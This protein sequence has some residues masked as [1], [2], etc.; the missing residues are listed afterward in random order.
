MCLACISGTKTGFSCEETQ[1]LLASEIAVL[2]AATGKTSY[3]YD[4]AAGQITRDNTKWNDGGTNYLGTAGQV[5][6]AFSAT[7]DSGYARLSPTMMAFVDKAILAI[8]SVANIDFTR[9][10]SG[11]SGEQAFS[12]A[13]LISIQAEPGYGG[14]WASWGY[15]GAGPGQANQFSGATVSIGATADFSQD[16]AFGMELTLHE[17]AHAIGLLHPGDYN[18]SG[19]K[20]YANDAV[21]FEDS[22]QYSVM[23]YWSEANTGADFSTWVDGR[24]VGGGP[25]NL[26]LH[27]IAALQRLYGANMTTRTGDTVYGF[28]SNTGDSTWTLS[29]KYDS[30]T[31]AVWDAGGIDTLDVSGFSQAADIDLREDAF[32]SFGGLKWNFSIARGAIIENAIGGS[33]NDKLSGNVAG[34]TLAGNG[35]N[36]VLFGLGGNDVLNGGLGTDQMNGGEGDDWIYY[37][38]NDAWAGNGVAG[39]NGFDTLVFEMVWLA[40]DL[41]SYG[42]EQSALLLI[43]TAAELWNEVSR[44][45]DLDGSLVEEETIFDDG[46]SQ[47]VVHDVNDEHGW[48]EWIRNFDAVGELTSESFVGNEVAP[49][50]VNDSA[51]TNEDHA[52]AITGNVL[53][54]DSGH[55]LVVEKIGNLTFTGS[56]PRVVDG[57]YGKLTISADGSWSYTVDTTKPAFATLGAGQH[58]T[59][60]FGYTVKNP[61]GSSSA[62]ISIRIDGRNEPAPPLPVSD[63]GSVN[64]DSGQAASGNVLANDGGPDLSVAKVND[65]AVAST[66]VTKIVGQYG[67]LTIAADGAWSYALD[68]KKQAVDVLGADEQ[69][70]DVFTYEAANEYGFDNETLTIA[71]N[72]ADDAPRTIFG[73]SKNDSITAGAIVDIVFA[74]KG[75]DTVQGL[76]GDDILHGEAGKDTLRGGLGNDS[77]FGGNDD[78]VLYGDDGNDLLDAGSGKKNSLFGGNGTDQLFGG[79]GA[80]KLYGGNDDDRL[81]GGGGK[82]TL[83]GEEGDDILWGGVSSH[84]LYGGAGSDI[85]VLVRDN[86]AD[87]VKDFVNGVDKLSLSGTSLDFD[88]LLITASKSSAVIKS[89]DGSVSMIIANAAGLVDATDFVD[90]PDFVI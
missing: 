34:N 65:T 64:E 45:F 18:G 63:N 61:L 46:S 30:I 50:A 15:Y 36:D 37:D 54:N 20:S 66:G 39:G 53:G 27:D 84:S 43:D 2:G 76:A 58:V 24:Y 40:I 10:G 17:I 83:Y 28:N 67:T 60:E 51:T 81:S 78:D 25:T 41:A 12:D 42:F 3:S 49:A 87:T 57:I 38:A 35:G 48:S 90:V 26:M 32:S 73:T 71:I 89:K 29:D 85:F 75:N 44:F 33:G 21:Y 22:V 11:T 82:D 7:P 8:E 52:A 74:G 13:A 55:E 59:E 88:D 68:N 1:E 14:G 80:D 6:W 47:I 31:A 77:L 19:A 72:G 16:D 4:Q 5:T 79:S 70:F 62:T 69:L 23:S 9:M 56:T 86:T